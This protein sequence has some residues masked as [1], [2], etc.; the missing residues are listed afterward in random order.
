MATVLPAPSPATAPAAPDIE[1]LRHYRLRRV[2]REL[3]RNDCGGIVLFDPGNIRYATDS[4]NM[5]VWTLHNRFRC[6][7]VP[8]EGLATLFDFAYQIFG[9]QAEGLSTIAEVRQAHPII[10]FYK[11][12]RKAETV[13]AWAD[14]IAALF[15]AQG[16]KGSRLAYDCLD[17]LAAE[18]LKAQGLTILDGEPLMEHARLIKSSDEIA[19]MRRSLA[20]C[21]LA[22]Q[23]MRDALVPGII[24]NR[25]WAIL[26]QTNIEEGGDW[27]ETRLL[28]SGPRT[29]PWMQESSDRT[30]EPGDLVGIDTDMIGPYGYCADISRSFLCGDTRPSDEQ[31]RLYRHAWEQLSH[32][33][34]LVRPGRSFRDI[35][36]NEWPLP[37]EFAPYRYGIAHG[38]GIK[39]EWPFL[40]NLMDIEHLSDPDFELLPGMVICM[41]SY[42]GAKGG[43]E[44]IK[45]EDQ[46]LVTETGYERLSRF[47][48]EEALLR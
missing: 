28:S 40:P 26:H 11:G 5:A 12:S 24:E 8:A 9:S 1:R 29:N 42:I 14:E 23:R 2:Q 47:P 16:G 48:F 19:C 22:L 30:I 35:V 25:L 46:I 6:A 3:A 27:I 7:F 41:E 37:E 45:L 17:P 44:G 10:H 21:E 39:D 4:R 20:A 13:A 34:E 36:E 38:L 43:R 33:V 32:N 15:R 18:A 31:R